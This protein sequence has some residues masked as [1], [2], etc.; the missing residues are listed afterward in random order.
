MTIPKLNREWHVQNRM[1][2]KANLEQRIR[3]HQEHVK[4]CACRPMPATICGA[5]AQLSEK[6]L[7]RPVSVKRNKAT[8]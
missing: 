7:P 1:P 3:W 2:V 6:K 4:H 8:K 5:I